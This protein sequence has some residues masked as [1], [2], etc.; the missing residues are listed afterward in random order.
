LLFFHSRQLCGSISTHMLPIMVSVGSLREIVGK[1]KTIIFKKLNRIRHATSL[2]KWQVT[3]LL[4]F[5][6]LQVYTLDKQGC[7]ILDFSHLPT[8]KLDWHFYLST[9]VVHLPKYEI[10]SNFFITTLALF[11][12]SVL[13]YWGF[14][15][16]RISTHM[17]RLNDVWCYVK[18]SCLINDVPT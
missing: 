9:A 14:A 7:G 5:A 1:C 6:R 10:N 12:Q 2:T 4:P 11:N 8:G 16:T 3:G 13:V 17:T 18:L 15:K